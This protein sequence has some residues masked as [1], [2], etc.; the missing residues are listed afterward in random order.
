VTAWAT[1]FGTL[2]FLPVGVPALLGQDWA[3][4][5]PGGWWCL[6]YIAL[7]TSIVSYLL[8][9]WA[10]A[11]I[12]ASRVAVFT[13]LQPIVTALFAF[14]LFGEPLTLHF[15]AATAFVLTGVWLAERG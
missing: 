11:R 12:E 15:L 3:R 1:A 4:I 9:G 6:A 2:F 14:A 5:T 10:L 8:W 13:N 7:L